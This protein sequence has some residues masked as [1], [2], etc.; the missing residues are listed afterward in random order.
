LSTAAERR[1]PRLS[2]RTKRPCAPLPASLPDA[3]CRFIPMLMDGETLHDTAVAL[4]VCRH[5]PEL[6]PCHDWATHNVGLQGVVGGNTYG[7]CRKRWLKRQ[8]S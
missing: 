2:T 3:A 8:A 5:C 1:T 7:D 6:T 4:G